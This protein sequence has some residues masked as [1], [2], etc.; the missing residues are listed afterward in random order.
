MKPLVVFSVLLVVA[1]TCAA[2]R[3]TG[4]GAKTR[5]VVDRSVSTQALPA[6]LV[7]AGAR[8]LW[9]EK[10]FFEL[11]PDANAYRYTFAEELEARELCARIW[12]ELRSKSGAA[13]AYLDALVAVYA[14][15]FLREYICG[16]LREP[17]WT[18][19]DGLRMEQFE[20]WQQ[21]HLRN[22]RVET[23]AVASFSDK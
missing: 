19:P 5:I 23:K 10:K 8:S 22:H 21:E 13:D 20:R 11:N 18:A 16:F 14:A 2:Q 17:D 12:S 1:S 15:N 6:W 3:I 9:M 7:Y 4:R